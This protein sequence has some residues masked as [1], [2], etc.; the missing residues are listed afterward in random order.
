MKPNK[1]KN[2][3]LYVDDDTDDIQL[4]GEAFSKYSSDIELITAYNGIEALEILHELLDNGHQP[5]LI[6]L[7]INMPKLDGRETLLKIKEIPAVANV[8]MILFSTSS[9]SNDVAF[10]MKHNAEFVTKPTDYK[11]L[12]EIINSFMTYCM[13][14]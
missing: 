2:L 8:P 13:K 3:V 7:D 1:N 12:E 4:I 5:C 14:D 9:Q 6:I 11:Q 10:A